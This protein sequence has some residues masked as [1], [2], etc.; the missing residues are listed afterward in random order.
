LGVGP[1]ALLA[2]AAIK[3]HDEQIGRV[4]ALAVGL[5]IIAA[6]V[7]FYWMAEWRRKRG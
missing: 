1:T 2:A 5:A 7:V 3:S 6:G 4:S